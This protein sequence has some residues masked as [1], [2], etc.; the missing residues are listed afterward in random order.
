MVYEQT[1][2]TDTGGINGDL[3]QYADYPTNGVT[4]GVIVLEDAD[5]SISTAANPVINRGDHVIL[6]VNVSAAFTNGLGTRKDVFGQI[7][8][9][10]GSPGVIAFTTPAAYNDPV[11]ELQ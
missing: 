7:I 11:V 10:Q 8:P 6:A 1:F 9:E 5:D 3:F 2:Y 4:F